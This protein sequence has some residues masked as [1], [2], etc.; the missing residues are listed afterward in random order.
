MRRG[1]TT[2]R[3]VNVRVSLSTG[4]LKLFKVNGRRGE[5]DT[6]SSPTPAGGR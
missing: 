5:R 3:D 2:R 6:P 1:A 4:F